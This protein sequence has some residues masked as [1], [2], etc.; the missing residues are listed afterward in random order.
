[1]AKKLKKIVCED[2][3]AWNL[4]Q[5]NCRCVLVPISYNTEEAITKRL[6]RRLCA[7]AVINISI[8]S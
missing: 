7:E 3:A 1:M 2:S 5:L 4:P 6:L 8:N